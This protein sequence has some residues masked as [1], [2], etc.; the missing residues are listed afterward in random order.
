MDI[1]HVNTEINATITRAEIDQMVKT[2]IYV[3]CK[4]ENRPNDV[5]YEY[6]IIGS[7]VLFAIKSK[8]MR[9]RKYVEG[10]MLNDLKK[11]G[12]TFHL[13]YPDP[14]HEN[15]ACWNV[16]RFDLFGIDNGVDPNHSF[17]IWQPFNGKYK[18]TIRYLGGIRP[19]E[20][21]AKIHLN[22]LKESG[23]D[24]ETDMDWDK[25]R[26]AYENAYGMSPLAYVVKECTK[27]TGK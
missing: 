12:I 3:G 10:R 2:A 15:Y 23:F 9:V 22:K 17:D 7:N 25:F 20:E 13:V 6:Y 11:R 26:Q 14:M 16:A 24:Y 5:Q 21:G 4:R 8:Y 27:S 18:Y 1:N 19:R